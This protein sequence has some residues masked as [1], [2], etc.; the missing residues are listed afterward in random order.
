[1]GWTSDAPFAGETSVGAGGGVCAARSTAEIPRA[2]RTADRNE[3][4]LMAVS[5][6]IELVSCRVLLC[7][8][9]AGGKR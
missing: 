9:R 1:M 6:M 4:I 2:K 3:L 7:A 8:C 5:P